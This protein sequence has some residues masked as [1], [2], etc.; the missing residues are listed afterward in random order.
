[1]AAWSLGADGAEHGLE[2]WGRGQ[3]VPPA[4]VDASPSARD[5]TIA[6]PGGKQNWGRRSK[7]AA[8]DSARVPARGFFFCSSWS[9]FPNTLRSRENGT[10]NPW[11]CPPVSTSVRPQP[12]PILQIILFHLSVT[13]SCPTLCD[14]MDC[15]PPGSSF[16]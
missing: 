8:T 9:K 11:I 13:Q 15:S 2:P 3:H 4:L 6:P 7:I 14:P 5:P 10:V 12:K 16:C 1:M